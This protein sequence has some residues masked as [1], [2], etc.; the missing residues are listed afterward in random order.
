M[1]LY[2]AIVK[3]ELANSFMH[4]YNGSQLIFFSIGYM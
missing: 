2:I 3:E 1:Q 4:A